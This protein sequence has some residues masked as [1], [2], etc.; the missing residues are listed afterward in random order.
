ML[1]AWPDVPP[2][3]SEAAWPSP[4]VKR[5]SQGKNIKSPPYSLPKYIGVPVASPIPIKAYFSVDVLVFLI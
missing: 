3:A 1:L 2:S 4:S 5:A